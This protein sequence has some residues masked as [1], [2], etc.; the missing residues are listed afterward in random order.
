MPSLINDSIVPPNDL[1][2]ALNPCMVPLFINVPTLA[3]ICIPSLLPSIVPLLVKFSILVPLDIFTP[4]PWLL[5]IVS[6]L[7]KLDILALPK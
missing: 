7:T 3:F 5:L 1:I 2:G 6:L 4:A